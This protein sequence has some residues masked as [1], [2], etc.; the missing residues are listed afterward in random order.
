MQISVSQ[1]SKRYPGGKLALRDIDLNIPNGL[2]GLLGPNGAGKTTLMRILVTLLKPTSGQ[3]RV[4]DLDIRKNRK[5]IRRQIGYLPQDFS[6]FAKLTVWE[7][8]DYSACLNGILSKNKRRDRIDLLLESVGLFEARDR[9]TGKLSG[10][11]KRRLGVAQTLIGDPPLLVVDEPTV[12]LDPE[13]RIR[14]RNLLSD[15]SAQDRIILLSTHIVGDISS[16]CGNIALMDLGRII[17]NGPPADL[18]D[19]ARGKVWTISTGHEDLDSW[20]ERFP[21]ISTVPSESGYELRIVA[22]NLDAPEAIPAEPNLED[23]YIHYMQQAAS[24][25][26]T[27]AFENK[28]WG[29]KP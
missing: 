21:V 8:M 26:L 10:G 13:E 24:G 9:L 28:K 19:N 7:F 18:V 29:G 15:L 23:A 14:F 16:T 22:E 2:F 4:N 17:F 5:E 6:V 20:K 12:G 3:V 11:M 1:L 27:G 25:H